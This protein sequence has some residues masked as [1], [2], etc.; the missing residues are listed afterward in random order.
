VK[1]GIAKADAIAVRDAAD[2][3]LAAIHQIYSFYV[4]H[5]LAT[6]EESPPTMD[7]LSTRRRSILMSGLPYLVATIEGHVV[8]YAYA[9]PYRP[10]PAYRFTVEDSIYVEKD[11]HGRGIGKALLSALIKRCEVGPWKQMVAIIGDSGNAGSIALHRRMG[12]EPVGTLKAVG[13]KLGRWVDTVI[14]QRALGAAR[15]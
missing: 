10:R 11:S 14:L 13:F 1:P 12:F 8:G 2:A 15:P 7:E 6:F 5:S 4:W 3:D 9:S